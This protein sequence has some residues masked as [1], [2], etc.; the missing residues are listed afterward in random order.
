MENKFN[1]SFF[2]LILGANFILLLFGCFVIVGGGTLRSLGYLM[3]A[4][5]ILSLN[6]F[7]ALI[8][9][10]RGEYKEASCFFLS[11]LL[12]LLVGASTCLGA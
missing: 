3:I 7:V 10:I 1:W 9:M 12:V 11:G 8:F 5:G 6:V 2:L 4:G